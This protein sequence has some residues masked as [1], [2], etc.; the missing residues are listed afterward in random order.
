MSA[1]TKVLLNLSVAVVMTLVLLL[2][3]YRLGYDA[4]ERHLENKAQRTSCGVIRR[5]ND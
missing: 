1:T 3:G 5:V 4:A 2:G